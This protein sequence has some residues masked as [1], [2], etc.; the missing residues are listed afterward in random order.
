MKEILN[1]T[2][3]TNCICTTQHLSW[4]M[5]HIN[6]DVT[7]NTNGSPNLGQKTRPYNYQQQQ[8]QQK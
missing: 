8:K 6:S 2:I 1:L 5:K 7:L 4:R 3:R